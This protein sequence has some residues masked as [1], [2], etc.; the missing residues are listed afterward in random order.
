MQSADSRE[1]KLVVL[2]SGG[3]GKSALVIRLV[4][5]N[6]LEDYDPTIEDSYRKQ[7][8]I[9]QKQALL[10]ILDTAGQ[11]EYTTMQDQWMREGKGFLLVY[12]I[13]S[14][15]TFDE[16]KTFKDKILRAK[17]TNRVSMVLVGNK[18][19]L[20]RNRD[21]SFAEGQALAREWGWSLH[22]DNEDCFFQV[23]REIRTMDAPKK[24]PTTKK[25]SP[26]KEKKSFC[27]IL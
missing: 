6:F 5:D 7:V 22:G 2:G 18:C 25:P 15:T 3:V 26:T 21:V 10:D 14:R 17:D 16:I 12:S 8:V 27:T 24:A 1:Y 11:E 13:T 19:D 9:D 4:T 23:V 20:E